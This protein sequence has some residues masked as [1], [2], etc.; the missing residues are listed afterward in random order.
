MAPSPTG[1]RNDDIEKDAGGAG[2]QLTLTRSLSTSSGDYIKQQTGDDDVLARKMVHIN[3][4]WDEV[5]FTSHHIKLFF[6]NGFGYAVDSMLVVCQSISQAQV[7]LEFT[8]RGV[9]KLLAVSL[10]SSIGLLFGALVWGIGGDFIGRK[11]AFNSSLFICAIFVIIAGSMPSY[12]SFCAMVALYSAGAGGNYAIDSTNFLEFLPHKYG[13]LT[14]ILAAWWGVGYTI[15]GLFA[16]LYFPRWSCATADTCTW[17]NNKGWRLL[18]FTNGGIVLVLALV[19]VLLFKMEHSPKWLVTQGRDE[20]AVNV[21]QSIARKTGKPCS[22]TLDTLLAEG[23]VKTRHDKSF[24]GFKRT[25]KTLF[26]TRK[27]AWS[28]VCLFFLWFLIGIAN[29]LYSVFRPYYL[30]TRGYSSGAASPYITWRNYTITN[31]CGLVGPFLAWPLLDTP[32]I[33]RRGTLAIG[34]A[35]TMAF[36]FGFTQVKT[37]TENLIVSSFINAVENIFFG[38]LYGVTP[39]LLP[40]GSRATGYGICV[41]INRVCNIIANIIGTYAN[42]Y[43]SAPL[44][45]CASLFAGLVVVSLALPLDPSGHHIG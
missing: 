21:I 12:S 26:I 41:A 34:A 14:T 11:L 30:S 28:T 42:V 8:N 27:Q 9:T 35:L 40:T 25:L 37:G 39:E 13:F 29:P 2:E 22:L 5:G 10:S 17:S 24:Q 16:W 19:R 44:F 43:T 6:L 33:R 23:D 7:Q 15:A 45:V 18:H 36:L 4:A 3:N 31:I 38:A 20:E 32:Y 1:S